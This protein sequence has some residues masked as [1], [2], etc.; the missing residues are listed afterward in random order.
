MP[1]FLAWLVVLS[2]GG[3]GLFVVTPFL[4]TRRAL[5]RRNR[6]GREGPPAPA[7]WVLVPDR[8]ARLHR[9][10]VRLCQL[11]RPVKGRPTGPALLVEQ[12][13]VAI[14]RELVVSVGSRGGRRS[15]LLDGLEARIDRLESIVVRLGRVE[16]PATLELTARSADPLAELEDRIRSLEGAWEEVHRAERPPGA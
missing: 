3:F 10:L 6:V 1:E 12:E 15:E 2:A 4:I 11:T 16:R 14:D 7:H 5:R 9:R 13:A 8:A